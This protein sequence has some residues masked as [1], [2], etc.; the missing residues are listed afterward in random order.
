MINSFNIWWQQDETLNP[1]GM[2][3]ATESWL[4]FGWQTGVPETQMTEQAMGATV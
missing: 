4:S 2:Q 1:M 3:Q